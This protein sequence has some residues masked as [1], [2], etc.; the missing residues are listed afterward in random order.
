MGWNPESQDWDL[1]VR[2][3]ALGEAR[4]RVVVE[5][6]GGARRLGRLSALISP[7]KSVQWAQA[8]LAMTAAAMGALGLWVPLAVVGLFLALLWVTPT[9]EASRLEAA[10]R[11]TADEVVSELMAGEPDAPRSG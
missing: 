5:H 7:S 3:G 8:A 9:A 2:R 4:V 6:H 1:K 10:L 11:S